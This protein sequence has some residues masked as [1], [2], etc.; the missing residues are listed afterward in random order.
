MLMYLKNNP[1]QSLH[2]KL[3]G[4][5]LGKTNMWIHVLLPILGNTL[6][7]LG[8]APSRQVEHLRERLEI[9]TDPPF[10]ATMEPSGR[11][12]GPRIPRSRGA[13]TAGRRNTTP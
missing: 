4:M 7:N 6:R 1:V 13:T 11:S 9:K 5:P 8:F 10:F 2:G 3:F 12:N